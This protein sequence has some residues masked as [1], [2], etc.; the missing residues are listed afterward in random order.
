MSED[1]DKNVELLKKWGF[2]FNVEKGRWEYGST[3][4]TVENL[5]RYKGASLIS[6]ILKAREREKAR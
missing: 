5:N 3:Y 2:K 4:V 6:F 1:F